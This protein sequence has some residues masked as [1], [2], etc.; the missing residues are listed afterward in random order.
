LTIVDGIPNVILNVDH[1]QIHHWPELRRAI[2]TARSDGYAFFD[3][4]G[5]I[6]YAMVYDK[7]RANPEYLKQSSVREDVQERLV[8]NEDGVR[9]SLTV[10]QIPMREDRDLG[11]A[12]VMRFFSY[13]IP[14]RAKADLIHGRLL[15]VAMINTGRLDRALAERGFAIEPENSNL[16]E[17]GY[18]YTV[19][20]KWPTGETECLAIPYTSVQHHMHTAIHEFSGLNYVVDHIAAIRRMP[21]AISRE[22]WLTGVEPVAGNGKGRT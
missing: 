19:D 18:P 21:E 1:H 2:R 17:R 5:F 16:A 22:D 11:G 3:L 12:P 13:D 14:K 6:G 9:N 15:I 8:S 4:D 20:L 10:Q 7:H